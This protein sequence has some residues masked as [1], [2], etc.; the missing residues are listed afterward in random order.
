MKEILK[1]HQ[2]RTCWRQTF[3][4]I[5]ILL[6]ATSH[7]FVCCYLW[8]SVFKKY[9]CAL[10]QGLCEA[11]SGGS[12]SCSFVNKNMDVCICFVL[13]RF[14]RLVRHVSRPVCVYKVGK[15]VCSVATLIIPQYRQMEDWQRKGSWMLLIKTFL[16]CKCKLVFMVVPETLGAVKLSVLPKMLRFIHMMS[17]YPHIWYIF[18]I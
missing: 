1:I 9:T 4:R 13:F 15:Q 6:F 12:H 2:D 16:V 7:L 8:F 17:L 11:F 5:A 14:F 10:Q 3:P 18:M